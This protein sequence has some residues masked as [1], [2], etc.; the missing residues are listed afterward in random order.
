MKKFEV[1]R[2]HAS[3]KHPVDKAGRH[4]LMSDACNYERRVKLWNFNHPGASTA[5]SDLA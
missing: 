4:I 2:V 5:E 3:W 1:S